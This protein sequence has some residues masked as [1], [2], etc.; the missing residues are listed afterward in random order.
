MLLELNNPE[1]DDS[2]ATIL[3]ELYDSDHAPVPVP[4]AIE[5]VDPDSDTEPPEINAEIN[6]VHEQMLNDEMRIHAWDNY[7]S[8]ILDN[9]YNL[10]VDV[11]RMGTNDVQWIADMDPLWAPLPDLRWN[12][13][14]I[15]QLHEDND[16]REVMWVVDTLWTNIAMLQPLPNGNLDP[17]TAEGT[18]DEERTAAEATCGETE[19]EV[20]GDI[21]VRVMID[22]DNGRVMIDDDD[23]RV[24]IDDDDEVRVMI[25]D[26]LQMTIN[27]SVLSMDDANLQSKDVGDEQ[28][29]DVG[30]VQSK[31]GGDVQSKDGGDVQSKDSGDVKSKNDGGRLRRLSLDAFVIFFIIIIVVVAKIFIFD[32]FISGQI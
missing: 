6:V 4:D 24:M 8:E 2:V 17:L 15:Q 32:F 22:D 21:E 29:K 13:D 5:I 1:N 28:S 27:D 30:D 26:E 18:N 16:D 25:D 9:D 31:D 20:V 14:E 7:M 23:G 19:Q 11:E 12:T 3:M 10:T